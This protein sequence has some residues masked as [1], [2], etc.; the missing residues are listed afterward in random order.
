RDEHQDEQEQHEHE[1]DEPGGEPAAD[2]GEVEGNR[3]PLG[4]LDVEALLEK[5]VDEEL[6]GGRARR[7]LAAGSYEIA[8]WAIS[9]RPTRFVL[10]RPGHS[11]R[12]Q[13]TASRNVSSAPSARISERAGGAHAAFFGAFAVP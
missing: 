8:L 5:A 13:S 11:F 2:A 1:V 12:L 4:G 10:R 3:H 7:P 6:H 9:R